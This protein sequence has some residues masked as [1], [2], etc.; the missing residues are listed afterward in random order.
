MSFD[1]PPQI[2]ALAAALSYA[3]SGISARRGMRHARVDVRAHDRQSVCRE[4]VG[5]EEKLLLHRDRIRRH[6]RA[7]YSGR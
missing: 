4:I 5:T 1:T 2:I 3:A 7:T 6:L